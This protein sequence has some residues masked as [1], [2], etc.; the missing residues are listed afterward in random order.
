MRVPG[1]NATA[2]IAM[3]PV[4]LEAARRRSVISELQ[5]NKRGLNNYGRIYKRS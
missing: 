4:S 1:S 2:Y 5:A 3:I